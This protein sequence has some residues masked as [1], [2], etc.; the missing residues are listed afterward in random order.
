[1]DF[2]AEI[3]KQQYYKDVSEI[4]PQAIKV[5]SRNA[6]GSLGECVS[7]WKPDVTLNGN[8]QT[9]GA[10]VLNLLQ[11]T[12]GQAS[13]LLCASTATLKTAIAEAKISESEILGG[14]APKSSSLNVYA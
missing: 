7:L 10:D 8:L 6:D 13:A 3:R 14:N 11:Q 12:Q 1:M 5:I 2:E 4:C 9:N